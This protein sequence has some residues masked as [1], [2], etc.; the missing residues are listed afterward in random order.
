VSA[1][2]IASQ[3]YST[4]RGK[5]PR[6]LIFHTAEGATDAAQ[7]ARWFA[8]ST[9]Q[10]S[11]HVAIDDTTTVRCVPDELAA[12][13]ARSANS[14]A[15]QAELC[16]FARWDAAEWVRHPGLLEQAA[17]WAADT[18]T[19]WSI[20]LVRL[21]D[22]QTVT[23]SGVCQH[24]DIT[25][26]WRTGT[27]TDCGPAFPL[28]AVIARAVELSGKPA[29]VKA[30]AAAPAKPATTAPPFPL[31]KGSYFG[32]EEGP[33]ESVSGHHGHRAAL[34]GWQAQLV[35]RGWKLDVD[36]YYG[37][38]TAGVARAF[39]RDKGLTVDGKVGP[40]TWAA[41]WTAPVT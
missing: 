8:Y 19:R 38:Q 28:D 22:E 18:A 34:A 20:P 1:L 25:R 10:V 3:N 30:P 29:S 32:P 11:S 13:T 6:L 36:G 4:R 15:I 39:Q 7:L 14:V 41:A 27:H 23:G 33:R 2:T 5:R 24:V 31:P 21:V 9:T 37:E 35:H 17:A 16:A 12:W 26:G 40:L